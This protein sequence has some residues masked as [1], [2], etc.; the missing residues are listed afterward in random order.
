MDGH[1]QMEK[2]VRFEQ[3]SSYGLSSAF[4]LHEFQ[5]SLTLVLLVLLGGTFHMRCCVFFFCVWLPYTRLRSLPDSTVGCTL[6]RI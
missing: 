5:N 1:R 3:R 2:D 4:A 6:M